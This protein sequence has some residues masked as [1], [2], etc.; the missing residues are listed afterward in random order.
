MSDQ[1]HSRTHSWTNPAVVAEKLRSS[2]NSLAGMIRGEIPP[3]PI[4]QTLDFY[5][6]FAEDGTAIFASTPAEFHF[7]PIG[8]VHG[9]FSAALLD[10]ALAVAI[11]SRLPAGQSAATIDLNITFIRPI[12]LETGRVRAIAKVIHIGRQ[13]ATAEAKLL[14]AKEKLYTHANGTFMVVN[15]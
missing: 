6:E 7:N 3:P 12:T 13:I 2:D 9:A 11:Q 5:L 4:G 14:D 8:V 1:I 15:I 10:S